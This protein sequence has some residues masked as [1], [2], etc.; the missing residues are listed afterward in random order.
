ML[1]LG[2][3]MRNFGSSAINLAY[4]ASGKIDAFWAISLYAWDIAA[5]KLLIEEAG[6]RVTTYRG[7]TYDVLTHPPLVATNGLV[8]EELLS[9]LK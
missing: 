5:G 3:L 2:T 4:V 8:H 6:G 7:E 9:Y 1:K